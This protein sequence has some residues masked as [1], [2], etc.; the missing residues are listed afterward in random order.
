MQCVL[1]W[2]GIDQQTCKRGGKILSTKKIKRVFWKHATFYTHSSFSAKTRLVQPDNTSTICTHTQVRKSHTFQRKPLQ[3]IRSRSHRV[4]SKC[5][6]HRQTFGDGE[7]NCPSVSFISIL[8]LAVWYILLLNC[9]Q[10]SMP[11]D[12]C[13]M[14]FVLFKGCGLNVIGFY[15]ELQS[16]WGRSN[17]G[18]G[19]ILLTVR[20]LKGFKS[21]SMPTTYVFSIQV[22]ANIPL[23][24][25]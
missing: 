22:K 21:F 19:N 16:D 13:N 2:R 3:Y 9:S 17:S 15:F 5:R 25:S 8:S 18:I 23:C 24:E 4:T 14:L 20:Q 12:S 6:R 7:S 11:G 1:R 10:F